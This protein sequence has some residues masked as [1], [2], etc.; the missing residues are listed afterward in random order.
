[1]KSVATVVIFL[2]YFLIFI[3]T[4]PITIFSFL[5]LCDLFPDHFILKNIESESVA[6]VVFICYCCAYFLF[7]K[8]MATAQQPIF[9][10]D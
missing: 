6:A 5:F 2:S 4:Q 10:R 1:M 3:S 8:L 9:C 7:S